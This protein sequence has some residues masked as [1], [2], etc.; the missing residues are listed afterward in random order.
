[1]GD[2]GIE[3][4]L[5]VLLHIRKVFWKADCEAWHGLTII[6]LQQTQN[7]AKPNT[8]QTAGQAIH[9]P[10]SIVCTDD[11]ASLTLIEGTV[12]RG[13]G[14]AGGDVDSTRITAVPTFPSPPPKNKRM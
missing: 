1:M 6:Q 9:R 2:S 8:G 13:A 3:R 4:D 12:E 5:D 11:E 14:G 7:A 10:Q